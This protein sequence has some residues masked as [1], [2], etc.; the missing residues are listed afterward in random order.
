VIWKPIVRGMVTYLP[1]VEKRIAKATRGTDSA[2]YCYSVW[3]RHL[4][5]ARAHGLV[6]D[7]R[8]VAELGPGDSLGIGLA[9]LLTGAT[10][11]VGL[12]R[13]AY[14]DP[15][16]NAAVL[17]ELLALFRAR[18]AI[19]DAGEFPELKPYLPSYEFPA[20]L[21]SPARMDSCL[22]ETRVDAIRAA[23]RN[24][25]DESGAITIAYRAPWSDP[26]VVRRGAIDMIYS[27]AVLEHVDDL[28]GTYAALAEWLKPGGVASHQISFVSHGLTPEWNGHW[29]IADPVWKVIRGRRPYLLNREPASTHVRLIKRSGLNAV[30]EV[31]VQIASGIE[32]SRLA[33]RFRSLSDEDLTTKAIFL[34]AVKPE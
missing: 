30:G 18:T 27:Q 13:V 1:V 8:V 32:R 4:V 9:A 10:R 14:A 6:D 2:R 23:L 29:A 34:Q 20:A 21:L 15:A 31:R 16:R 25:N 19:P 3:L 24:L 12:D 7:P 11:Y 5:M 28:E 33:R 17:D 26:A 22:Q